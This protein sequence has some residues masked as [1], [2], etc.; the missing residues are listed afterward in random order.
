MVEVLVGRGDGVDA[1]LL[2]LLHH[3]DCRR[4]LGAEQLVSDLNLRLK[5][6]GL[7]A[8]CGIGRLLVATR[9]PVEDA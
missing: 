5:H 7:E 1:P 3:R 8:L 6:L 2:A 4:K 9:L